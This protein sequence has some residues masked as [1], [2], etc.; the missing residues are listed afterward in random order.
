MQQFS[1]I[2]RPDRAVRNRLRASCIHRGDE[3]GIIETMSGAV[4]PHD[5]TLMGTSGR[6]VNLWHDAM[7]LGGISLHYVDYNC[8]ANR[9]AVRTQTAGESI[10][11]KFPLVSPSLV[12]VNEQEYLVHPG[13]FSVLNSANPFQ[14]TMEGE[15][16]HIALVIK[17]PW[18]EQYFAEQ[19]RR[20][21]QHALIFRDKAYDVSTDGVLLSGV[22]T[23]LVFSM[24]RHDYS[25]AAVEDV[26]RH[27]KKLITAVVVD[28]AEEIAEPCLSDGGTRLEPRFLSAAECFMQKNLAE[29]INVEDVAR[30]V[31]VSRRT[32]HAGFRRYRDNSPMV[33][34]KSFR[35]TAVRTALEDPRYNN[36]SVTEIATYF[37]FYHLGR[38]SQ[39][40]RNAF[41]ILPSQARKHRILGQSATAQNIQ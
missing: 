26:S 2:V 41:G 18:L 17:K 24:S 11:L 5:F 4:T 34:L 14:T 23:S 12:N 20:Y 13:E 19:N 39:E 15:S 25:I 35:L 30:H 31:G 27:T 21:H 10:V 7:D 9:I 37:G 6:K 22:L 16:S 40:Y 29:E 38:F 32:L 36:K 3:A 8:D 28:L 33:I 1:E